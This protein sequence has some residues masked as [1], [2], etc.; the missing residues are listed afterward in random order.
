VVTPPTAVLAYAVVNFERA[1][2]DDDPDTEAVT[3]ADAREIRAGVGLF[4]RR[5]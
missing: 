4:D 5:N 1:T 3:D 2:L